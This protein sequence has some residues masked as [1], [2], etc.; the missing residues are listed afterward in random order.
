MGIQYERAPSPPPPRPE[1]NHNEYRRQEDDGAE[2]VHGAIIQPDFGEDAKMNKWQPIETAPKDGTWI[3]LRGRNSV[4]RPM[5]PVVAAW[6]HGR[7]LDD[8]YCWRDS[9]NLNDMTDLAASPGGAEWMPLPD[10]L[11]IKKGG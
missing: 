11:L 10:E 9:A 8:P 5:V 6:T 1:E 7:G 2:I 4:G 3:L